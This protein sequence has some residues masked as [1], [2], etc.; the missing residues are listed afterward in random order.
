MPSSQQKSR[1]SIVGKAANSLR[2]TLNTPPSSIV[3]NNYK[4]ISEE[5]INKYNASVN[6]LKKITNNKLSELADPGAKRDYLTRIKVNA[7]F[8]KI[9]EIGK[10]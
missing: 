10:F 6:Y 8:L 3:Q 2:S 7:C 9:G 5:A 1:D 4:P